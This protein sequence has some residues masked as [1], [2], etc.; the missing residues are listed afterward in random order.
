MRVPAAS[1]RRRLEKLKP[2]GGWSLL[3]R[4]VDAHSFGITC[5]TITYSIR[6]IVNFWPC[7]V[8]SSFSHSCVS[9]SHLLSSYISLP[10]LLPRV[11][12]TLSASCTSLTYTPSPLSGE[13]LTTLLALP[14][15]L[16]FPCC[17]MPLIHVPIFVF[18]SS[19]YTLSFLDVW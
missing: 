11:F 1:A 2:D 3:M 17:F 5:L 14:L 10:P 9:V 15:Y 6:L 8:F 4:H 13:I 7:N 16:S 19:C 12:H 18:T